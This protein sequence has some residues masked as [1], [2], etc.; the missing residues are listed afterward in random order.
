M[1]NLLVFTHTSLVSIKEMQMICNHEKQVRYL[2][3]ANLGLV[4]KWYDIAL[5]MLKSRVRT[6]PSLDFFSG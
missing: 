6:P 5:S 4:V 3:W 2:H 1:F